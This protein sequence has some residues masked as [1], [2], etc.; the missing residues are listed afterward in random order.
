[1]ESD[2]SEDDQMDVQEELR[3]LRFQ[4]G[5][6]VTFGQASVPPPASLLSFAGMTTDPRQQVVPRHGGAAA[7]MSSAPTGCMTAGDGADGGVPPRGGSCAELGEDSET[8]SIDDMLMGSEEEESP[9]SIC[10]ES[11]VR[12]PDGVSTARSQQV[13]GCGAP[14]FGLRPINF[15]MFACL[16]GLLCFGI[17]GVTAGLGD[18]FDTN[19]GNSVT[20]VPV[21]CIGAACIYSGVDQFSPET[22]QLVLQLF[23]KAGGGTAAAASGYSPKTGYTFDNVDAEADY[24]V[25]VLVSSLSN[26]LMPI[27]HNEF[28]KLL[29]R[30]HNYAYYHVTLDEVIFSIL[31]RTVLRGNALA[32]VPREVA[33]DH[34][35]IEGLT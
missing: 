35:A 14:P 26:T 31:P 15:P 28:S 13:V 5:K 30:E 9:P 22:R 25:V 20:E 32:S 34:L 21:M 1:M 11:F 29:D 4:I 24:I 10:D 33:R 23:A 17:A 2:D 6:A 18:V 7:A 19:D 3:Q 27:S 16:V 8:Q 12:A